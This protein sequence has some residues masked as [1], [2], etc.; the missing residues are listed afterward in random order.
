[1][2]KI[3]QKKIDFIQSLYPSYKKGEV[4]LSEIARRAG[5]A[6]STA[7]N[8]TVVLEQESTPQEYRDSLAKKRGFESESDYARTQAKKRQRRV[9]YKRLGSL[10][11]TR[12]KKLGKNYSWLAEEAET[13]RAS[14]SLYG[15]GKIMPG[16]E[17]LKKIFDALGVKYKT[18][19]DVLKG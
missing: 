4:S 15:Q 1:M 19:D 6:L 12:L 17:T 8:Y 10:I 11:K 3:S 16:E 18:L 2:P 13:T 5:V 9:K 14:I 7:R